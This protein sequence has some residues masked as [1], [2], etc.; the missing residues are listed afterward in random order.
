[1][2][3]QHSHEVKEFVKSFQVDAN[4][5]FCLV[6]IQTYQPYCP[7]KSWTPPCEFINSDITMVVVVFV[8]CNRTWLGVPALVQMGDLWLLVVRTLLSNCLR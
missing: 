5:A 2:T 7:N 6:C 4:F 1:M 3:W 8:M